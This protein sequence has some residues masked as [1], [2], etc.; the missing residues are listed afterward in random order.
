MAVRA[1]QKRLQ[2][3]HLAWLSLVV[4]TSVLAGGEAGCAGLWPGVLICAGLPV[5][6]SAI[7][8]SQAPVSD[9][10]RRLLAISWIG[11][12]AL[13]LA[14][15]G[16]AASPFTIYLLIA[17][18]V[19]LTLDDRR[20]AVESSVFGM[21]AYASIGLTGLVTHG[22]PSPPPVGLTVYGVVLAG[23]A[24]AGV[25]A[26][27]VFRSQAEPV[28]QA[29]PRP[30][31]P[32][33]ALPQASGHLLLSISPEGR[34]RTFS[35][36]R[37]ALDGLKVG[38]RL[39]ALWPDAETALTPGAPPR[40]STRLANGQH[41]SWA[42]E[43]SPTGWHLLL[44][45]TQAAYF[46]SLG[47]E[48]KT[49]LGII[50]GYSEMM[51]SGLMGDL[52]KPHDDYAAIIHETGQD[53][54]LRVEDLLELARAEAGQ[55]AL[56]TEPVDLTASGRHVM[57]QLAPMAAR[58]GVAM[59]FESGDSVWSEADGRAVTQIWQNLVS[60]A[61]KFSDAGGQVMLST[62]ALGPMAVLRVIDKGI[63]MSPDDLAR[64]AE[65]FQRGGNIENREGT[66]LGL[67]IVRSLTERMGGRMDIYSEKGRGT[68]I[69]IVLV[70]AGE[71]DREPRAKGII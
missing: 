9:V 16:G 44:S 30:A 29:E 65:P 38:A 47:H 33:P 69:D 26:A 34:V 18:L 64:A 3:L 5:L 15:T 49:P 70:H 25:L 66:G 31:P 58:R 12:A 8:L 45:Q 57:M 43:A 52:P 14:M 36:D 60:N 53:L 42:A 40:G 67:A 23:V 17:P 37:Q 22:L 68:Q 35:G 56:Q 20:L 39:A 28:I 4:L 11:F 41:V 27:T 13:G 54:L 21:L 32:M 10:T 62:H 71:E 1:V 59:D 55:R 63:G 46:A 7:G 50:L 51:T 6:V 24:L 2:F 19:A 61:I 48:L